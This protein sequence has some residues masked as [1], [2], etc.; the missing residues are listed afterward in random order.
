MFRPLARATSRDAIVSFPAFA[1]TVAVPARSPVITT[2]P[3][4]PF[5]QPRRRVA[6]EPDEAARTASV[7]GPSG[8]TT[9]P[10]AE[11]LDPLA[12][13]LDPLSGPDDPPVGVVGVG[14]TGAGRTGVVNV[15]S[16]PSVGPSSSVATTR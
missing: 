13:L 9:G 7:K 15:S 6:I 4:S 2:P 5:G 11:A 3:A 8:G 16:V 10:L 12:E 14:V 1:V